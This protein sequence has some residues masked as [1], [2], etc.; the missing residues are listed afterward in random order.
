MFTA[1]LAAAGATA[2]GSI[3]GVTGAAAVDWAMIAIRF[4]LH[5]M[6]NGAQY[7]RGQ[8]QMRIPHAALFS[9]AYRSL[10]LALF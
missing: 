8:A 3:S 10:R 1:A 5:L 2:R 4:L 9:N 7:G 6:I